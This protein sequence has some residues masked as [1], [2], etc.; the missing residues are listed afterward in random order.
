MFARLPVVF[1]A[2]ILFLTSYL[3]SPISLAHAQGSDPTPEAVQTACEPDSAIECSNSVGSGHRYCVDNP[4]DRSKNRFQTDCQIEVCATTGAAPSGDPPICPLAKAVNTGVGATTPSTSTCDPAD[5]T[6]YPT[7]SLG[8]TATAATFGPAE[9]AGFSLENLLGNGFACMLGPVAL[10]GFCGHP[11]KASDGKTVTKLSLLSP[12]GGALG[13]AGQGLAMLYSN[14]PLS[15]T[16]YL[17][18][19][20]RSGF[21]IAPQP[22]YAQVTGT[23]SLVIA[24]VL[25]FW[26]I[27]R[28]LAYF[29][30]I[31]IFIYIG[32]AIMFRAKLGGAAIT[33][34]AA[35]PGIIVSL[36]LVTF[37]YF[38]AGLLID[39][40]FWGSQFIG[41]L[42][43]TQVAGATA[44]DAATRV[45][46][47]L[48]KDI[49]S[50]STSLMTNPGAVG[51]TVSQVNSAITGIVGQGWTRAGLGVAGAIAGC[52]NPLTGIVTVLGGPAG[53][54][55]CG[56]GAAVGG[57][58]GLIG[59]EII[60]VVAYLVL[61]IGILQAVFR[62]FF[63]L[64]GS[65]V[66]IV[67]STILGPLTLMTSAIPGR[68]KTAE[69]WA[70]GILANA[71]IFP[72]V[73]AA[74]LFAAAL[75]N[76]GDPWTIGS[77]IP[78][79]DHGLPLFGGFQVGF[80]NLL[81]AYGILFMTPT[82]PG[83]VK[84]FFG[85]K[86]NN[87]IQQAVLGGL[88]GG[89][90]G[91]GQIRGLALNGGERAINYG[92][93]RLKLGQAGRLK[94]LRERWEARKLRLA[95]AAAKK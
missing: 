73:F 68:G 42:I 20:I 92:F 23:G 61:L 4:D 35:I 59:P 53:L 78:P 18:D 58:L 81:L 94:I 22:A 7:G 83:Q 77:S 66:S 6:T 80:I 9:F 54:G 60:S 72:A 30:Y 26:Q 27:T 79:F 75:L 32:F 49:I 28:N 55:A 71:L 46:G 19:N 85:V 10:R 3:L 88:A 43:Y 34:Q 33:A 64:I 16:Q 90:T 29:M 31:F 38:I 37:S 48:G 52:V 8:C 87:Q 86:D 12:N 47:L 21:G 89:W 15:G 74:F 62:L 57:A 82:I 17:V 44:S 2:T 13:A 50:L 41:V 51:S 65:Y 40:A 14:Q 1:F 25:K 45:Q 36:I 24:P 95:E 63:Q 69:T 56:V 76:A 84:A 11:E 39:F 70:R 93:D 67:V 91:L 5:P